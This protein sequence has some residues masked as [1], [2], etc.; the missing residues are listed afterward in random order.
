[1]AGFEFSCDQTVVGPTVHVET[2]Y[3]EEGTYVINDQRVSQI[4]D[5]DQCLGWVFP[6]GSASLDSVVIDGVCFEGDQ[7]NET[8]IKDTGVKELS[9]IKVYKSMLD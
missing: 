5:M 1:M 6:D 2:Y 9:V 8:K 3:C 4:A 7:L